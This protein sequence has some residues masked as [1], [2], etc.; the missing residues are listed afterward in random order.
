MTRPLITQQELKRVLHYEPATGVLTWLRPSK[1]KPQLIGTVAGAVSTGGYI[2]VHIGDRKYKGHYLAW[3]YVTGEWPSANILHIN[4]DCGDNRFCNLRERPKKR[5]RHDVTQA[6]LQAL[7]IYDPI[8]GIFVRRINRGKCKAGEVF[9]CRNPDGYLLGHVHGHLYMLHRLAWLYVHGAW[10]TKF[11]DHRN[12]IK[13]DNRIE[14]L[15]EATNAE[16]CRNRGKT[17][18]NTSGYKC[19]HQNKRTQKWV[20]VISYWDGVTTRGKHIGTFTTKE[21]AAEAYRI[22]VEREH[23]EFARVE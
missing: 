18:L 12:T 6:E 11:L 13:D 1:Y 14:N 21:E 9:G 19:V 23:G 15:R 5:P 10:P 7:F 2:D 4:G 20:A 3:L 22:A 17:V 8:T 16:N